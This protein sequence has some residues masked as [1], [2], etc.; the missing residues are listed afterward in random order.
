MCVLLPTALTAAMTYRAWREDHRQLA[1]Q[2][3]VGNSM[4]P[5]RV[6]RFDVW[7]DSLALRGT[8]VPPE[9]GVPPR[10]SLGSVPDASPA[11][12]RSPRDVSRPNVKRTISGTQLKTGFTKDE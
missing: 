11:E 3:P 4:S 7:P 6:P 9:P 5:A 2:N 12:P 1:L 10:I 8:G